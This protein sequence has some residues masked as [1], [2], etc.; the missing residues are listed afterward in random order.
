MENSSFKR[1]LNENFRPRYEKLLEMFSLYSTLLERES[2]IHN[3]TALAP[4]EYDEKHFLDSLLLNEVFKFNDQSLIDIGTGAGFPGL[5]LAIAFPSLR[6]TLLEPTRK[7]CDFL[8]LVVEALNLTNVVIVN[9]KAEDYVKVARGT[10]DIAT[11]RAVASLPIILEL[12][13]PLVKINGNVIV[14]KGKQYQ[15][16]LESAKRAIKLLHIE[17]TKTAIHYLESDASVRIN[18]VFKKMGET[19]LNYPRPYAQIK[20]NPL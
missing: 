17:N 2:K 6:V 14:M 1:Y 12:S 11:S 13:V 7:R 10:F 16:E 8:A 4:T 19:S 20:K 3:L 9:K 15:D 5:V 18:A